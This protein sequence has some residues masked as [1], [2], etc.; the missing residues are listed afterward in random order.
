MKAEEKAKIEPEFNRAL[1]A[2]HDGDGDMA[3]QIL[4]RLASKYPN[5]AFILGMLGAIYQ[6]LDDNERAAGYFQQ[7][8][9]LSPKSE[10]AS[11]GLFHSLWQVGRRDEA[12]DEMTRFLSAASSEEYDLLIEESLGEVER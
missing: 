8:A 10:L 11:L 3:V 4:K 9:S 6:S 1:E 7:T 12:M 5:R 2:W